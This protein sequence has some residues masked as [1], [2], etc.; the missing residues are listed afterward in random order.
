MQQNIV[1]E[2][3]LTIKHKWYA[4]IN[5]SNGFILI[6]FL[7]DKKIKSNNNKN[8]IELPELKYKI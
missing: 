5:E 4:V 2:D 3:N 6:E 1:F 7:I 8:I